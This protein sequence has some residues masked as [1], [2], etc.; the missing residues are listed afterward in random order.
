M[1]ISHIQQQFDKRHTQIRELARRQYLQSCLHNMKKNEF[2]Q[3]SRNMNKTCKTK[4]HEP[5]ISNSTTSNYDS[6]IQEYFNNHFKPLTFTCIHLI[7]KSNVNFIKLYNWDLNSKLN[8]I[9][10]NSIY[11]YYTTGLKMILWSRNALPNQ[12]HNT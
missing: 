10:H 1:K 8:T 7:L 2:W 3:P 9:A 6:T 12:R 4:F 5:C 11:V